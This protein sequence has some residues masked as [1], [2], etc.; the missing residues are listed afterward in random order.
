MYIS[1]SR[2]HFDPLIFGF[3]GFAK[4]NV[5]SANPQSTLTQ[6]NLHVSEEKIDSF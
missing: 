6:I 5:F 4:L 1:G 3:S 2:G